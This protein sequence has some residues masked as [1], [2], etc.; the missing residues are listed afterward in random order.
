MVFTTYYYL[1]ASILALLVY[2]WLLFLKY[3][4]CSKIAA[5]YSLDFYFQM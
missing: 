1:I 5:A 3:E 4:Q 2:F